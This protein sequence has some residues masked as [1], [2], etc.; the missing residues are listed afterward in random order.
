MAPGPGVKVDAGDLNR[1]KFVLP[2]FC[3]Y[4]CPWLDCG[5]KLFTDTGEA[6]W[7]PGE[8]KST[9]SIAELSGSEAASEILVVLRV[10]CGIERNMEYPSCSDLTVGIERRKPPDCRGPICDAVSCEV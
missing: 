4:C 9:G 2:A 8:G 10:D 6:L 5:V 1:L 3:G 7:A